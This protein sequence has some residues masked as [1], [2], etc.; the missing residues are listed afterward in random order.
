MGKLKLAIFNVIAFILLLS[1][2]RLNAQHNGTHKCGADELHEQLIKN[3]EYLENYLKAYRHVHEKIGK[4]ERIP[5]SSPI[6]IPMAFHFNGGITNANMSCIMAQIQRQIDALNEDFGGYNS[7]INTYCAYSAAC[8]TQFPPTALGNNACIQFCLA[9]QNLP[10]GEPDAITFGQYTFTSG[11]SAWSGYFNVFVSDVA[12]PGQSAGLLGL[13]PLG[14]AANPNGNGMFITNTAFGG[15]AISCISGAPLNSSS[16]YNLGRTG[17]HEAGHY[18]GLKHIFAGCNN[19]DE[20]ADTPS[21]D[22]S[23]G[24]AP[25]VNTANCTSTAL[26]SCGSLDFFFNYMDYVNDAA[27]YMFTKN[28]DEVMNGYALQGNWK[29]NVTTCNAINNPIYPPAGCPAAAAPN[30][31]F[32]Q[33]YNGMPVCAALANIQ[34]TD[35]STGFPSVWSWTFSGAGVSPTTSNLQNPLVTFSSTGTIT[36][37]LT[38][39]NGAGTDPTPATQTISVIIDN[40]ANC[41]NCGQ[42]IFDPGG[43]SAN[44]PANQDASY[45][46]CADNPANVPQINFSLINIE[47]FMGSFAT[48]DHIKIYNGPTATGSPANYVFGNNIYT[49]N[50]SSLQTAGTTFT[51]TQQCVTFVFD[52]SGDSYPGWAAAISCIPKATCSDGIQNQGETF[53]D[54]GGPCSPCGSLCNNFQFTDAGGISN[55]AGPQ[56]QIWTTCADLASEHVIVDFSSINMT[57]FNNGILQ[58]FNGTTNTPPYAYYIAG[59]GIFTLNGT[60]LT[61]FGSTTIKSTGQCFTFSYFNG[62]NT[63]VGW[64]ANINCCSNGTCPAA[65]NNGMPFNVTLETTCPGFTNANFIS[66]FRQEEVSGPRA[67][68]TP[69]LEF[70]TY[71]AVK[72]DPNGGLLSVDVS[73]N[74]SGGN[75]QAGLYGPVTGSCPTYSGTG[76]TY[77]DCEDGVNPAPLT[78]TALP[79]ETYIVVIT[80]EN[81]GSFNVA[82][83]PNSTALPVNLVK[84][85]A[86]KKDN[87]ALLSWTTLSEVNNDGFVIMKSIDGKNFEALDFVK[88]KGNSSEEQVYQ[89]TDQDLSFGQYYYMLVQKDFD[90]NT[91]NSEVVNISFTADGNTIAVYPNPTKDLINLEG[92][93]VLKNV[94][95]FNALGQEISVSQNIVA[96]NKIQIQVS[97][98]PRG[99]YT[100]KAENN[101]SQF[102][103]Q[104]FIID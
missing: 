100:V 88:G 85:Q 30:S 67:C 7:D 32:T 12:P 18:F 75:V 36:A 64:V 22:Q 87:D 45:V 83:T 46:Y 35:A 24:G 4:G 93:G 103:K 94:K 19:G 40:P 50:G 77:V 11:A 9:T 82:S 6:M 42:N 13:A 86:N 15:D 38:A 84:F 53:V 23:N 104:I 62:S 27:M 48:T 63:S 17:T 76:A 80:S 41:G 60:T 51:G 25:T 61:P 52:N 101:L 31:A 96:E 1:C 95:L 78:R 97:N 65:T 54:C 69:G 14:G 37:T 47:P 28:Q 91:S 29:T 43:A 89:Y 21:Q 26:N 16:I 102:V 90:G 68:T 58:V 70:K 98:I 10:A 66:N 73:A 39:S 59:S 71:Y 49:L 8:P 3:P 5:C 72:C 33:N 2:F 44:Y 20:I 99:I 34:F 55:N 57:P 81:A 74:S 79:N 56:S 92:S